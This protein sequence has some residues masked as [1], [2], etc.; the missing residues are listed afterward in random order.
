MDVNGVK[1]GDNGSNKSMAYLNSFIDGARTGFFVLLAIAIS[2]GLYQRLSPS[3]KTLEGA[4]SESLS[5]V[6]L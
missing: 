1:I 2:N 5:G 6:G 3:K 4:V